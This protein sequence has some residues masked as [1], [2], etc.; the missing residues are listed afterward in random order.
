MSLLTGNIQ[1]KIVMLAFLS[2]IQVIIQRK[3]E[4]VSR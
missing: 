3:F 1:I 2:A 4:I